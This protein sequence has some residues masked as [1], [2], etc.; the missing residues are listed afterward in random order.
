[1]RD[2]NLLLPSAVQPTDTPE[3]LQSENRL[4]SCPIE[5]IIHAFVEGICGGAVSAIAVIIELMEMVFSNSG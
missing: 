5:H 1:M 4:Y 2:I 3:G